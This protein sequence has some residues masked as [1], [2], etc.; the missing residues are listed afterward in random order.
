VLAARV[1]WAMRRP[2]TRQKIAAAIV[3]SIISS[4]KD[5]DLLDRITGRVKPTAGLQA[6]KIFTKQV[7]ERGLS[8]HNG[9]PGPS[10][11]WRSTFWLYS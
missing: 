10:Y 7:L 5:T 3:D 1:A 2:S 11:A 4:G 6:I 9:N 8:V